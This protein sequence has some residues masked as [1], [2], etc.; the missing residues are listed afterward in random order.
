MQIQAVE[1]DDVFRPRARSVCYMVHQLLDYSEACLKSASC[2]IT[3]KSSQYAST[4]VRITAGLRITARHPLD[5]LAWHWSHWSG[6]SVNRGGGWLCSVQSPQNRLRR[7]N[8]S[9]GCQLLK[10]RRSVC[11]KRWW[12]GPRV[13]DTIDTSLSTWEVAQIRRG[14]GVILWLAETNSTLSATKV[15]TLQTLFE[16]P[17]KAGGYAQVDRNLDVPTVRFIS[18]SPAKQEQQKRF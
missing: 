12:R 18:R 17:S 14:V 7:L 13:K 15:L 4:R 1:K 10:R 2:T 9:V 8:H 11:E 3:C 6:T 5:L 16:P